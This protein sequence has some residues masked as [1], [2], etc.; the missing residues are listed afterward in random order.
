MHSWYTF[1]H[2]IDQAKY[3]V[4]WCCKANA[5][6]GELEEEKNQ[7]SHILYAFTRN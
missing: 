1:A 2:D 6:Q 3:I 5:G 7:H 4:G